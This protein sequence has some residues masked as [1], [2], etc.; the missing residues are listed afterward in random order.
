M[1]SDGSSSLSDFL[2]ALSDSCQSPVRL[3]DCQTVRL[4]SDYCQ[5]PLSDCQTKAQDELSWDTRILKPI[6]M[7]S[8]QAGVLLIRLIRA[9]VPVAQVVQL[10]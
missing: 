7:I 10:M 4:L 9:A 6:V 5:N 2:S 1:L 3:S 8:C